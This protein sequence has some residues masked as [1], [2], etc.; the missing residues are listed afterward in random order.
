LFAPRSSDSFAMPFIGG[1]N[2]GQGRI[3]AEER[4]QKTKKGGQE[5]SR[6]RVR[7]AKGE[8]KPES[9][10]YARRP[11]NGRR[12]FFNIQIARQWRSKTTSFYNPF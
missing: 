9:G 12:L 7:K 11:V 3:K 2:H 1:S 6:Y 8:L 10:P 5:A 4:S